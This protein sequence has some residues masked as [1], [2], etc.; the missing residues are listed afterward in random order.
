MAAN[1][2]VIM[3]SF[4]DKCVNE[5]IEVENATMFEHN[6]DN[7]AQLDCSLVE[8]A[9]ERINDDSHFKVEVSSS[10]NNDEVM[11]SN[12]C[13]FDWVCGDDCEY[14]AQDREEISK[15]RGNSMFEPLPFIQTHGDDEE[16]SEIQTSSSA[17]YD[18]SLFDYSF[19]YDTQADTP[20][21][22]E[23]IGNE[24]ACLAT[25]EPVA[26]CNEIVTLGSTL[27]DTYVEEDLFE[28][29]ENQGTI[30]EEDSIFHP[31]E[32]ETNIYHEDCCKDVLES[33]PF[34]F[35]VADNCL[36]DMHQCEYESF[37]FFDMPTYDEMRP[38]DPRC[39]VDIECFQF[40]V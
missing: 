40:L 19:V 1:D 14:C 7:N 24:N 27:F 6:A 26:Y 18:C 17:D 8:D 10:K 20:P 13:L 22:K 28:Y 29:G 25:H 39:M 16:Q 31:D 21:H 36:H 23:F 9:K 2:Q 3:A 38:D 15:Q 11:D 37:F 5:N 30:I 33:D 35:G 12:E 34:Q 4:E 32:R